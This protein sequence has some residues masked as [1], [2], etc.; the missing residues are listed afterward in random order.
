MDE[1]NY[2]SLYDTNGFLIYV[3]QVVTASDSPHLASVFVASLA[4]GAGLCAVVLAF[5]KAKAGLVG[6]SD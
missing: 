6:T 2:I 5:R 4:L 1:T 3:G